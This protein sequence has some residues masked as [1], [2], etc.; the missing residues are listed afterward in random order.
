MNRP[1]RY[2][3][4]EWGLKPRILVWIIPIFL[5]ASVLAVIFNYLM[6]KGNDEKRVEDYV[7][8]RRMD[9]IYL[10]SL[11]SL[12]MYLMNL[13]LG[14]EEEA[15]F[16]KED[17]QL[18]YLNYLKNQEPSFPHI[19]SL[20][21]LNG[22]ELL[23]IENGDIKP[24]HQGFSTSSYLAKIIASKHGENPSLPALRDQQLENS[25][26]V[27][28]FPIFSEINNKVVGGIVYEYQIPVQQLMKHSRGVFVFNILLSSISTFTA[29]AMINFALG[30]IIRPLNQL[31]EAAQKMLT[32]D[33]SKKIKVQG[34]GE[35]RAL[36]AA[37]ED[38]RQRLE[39]RIRELRDNSRKLEAIIDFLP[40]PTFIIDQDRKV[41]FWNIAMEEMTGLPREEVIGKG[42][43]KY[44]EPFYGEKRPVLID[45][46]FET[47]EEV[48]EKYQ[49][50]KQSNTGKIEASAWCPTLRGQNRMLH[51]TAAGL[52]DDA[53]NMFG[54]IESISD[55]TEHYEMEQEKK[56]LQSQLMHA[57]KLKA[58]GTL[59]GG[60]AHD[61]NNLIHAIQGYTEILLLERRPDADYKKLKAIEKAVKRA[62]ELT[63]QL[64]IFS[65]KAKSKLR[66]MDLNQELRETNNL[67]QRIIPKMTNIEL[68]LEEDLK[69]VY[70][71]S[72]Q[73]EQV[74]MNLA[75]NARDA[76][77]EGGRLIIE[78]ANTSLGESFC[79]QNPGSK[80]G[81]Y[82][83][84]RV[85]D[86]G[87][88]MDEETLVHIYEPFFTTKEVGKGTGLGLA[89]VYG[90]VKNHSGYI[91]CSS[92]LGK[93]T[94]FTIYLPV[95]T[96]VEETAEP[97][98]SGS[99][100]GGS[101][102]ILLVDDDE[103]IRTLGEDLLTT[104]GYTVLLAVDGEKGLELYQQKRQQIDLIVLD[105]IMP[106]MGGKKCLE[107]LRKINPN[108]KVIVASGYSHDEFGKETMD[109]DNINFLTKPY[110]TKKVLDLVREALSKN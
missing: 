9:L 45:L 65:R 20:V 106:G 15:A 4:I 2:R 79:K 97:E 109:S 42:D 72:L 5:V 46:V 110:Q 31:T 49:N 63:S 75:I 28:V 38:L 56:Q 27:D 62:G 36:A 108:V 77:P 95:S 54:A 14:L 35:T 74:I 24:T 60:I 58:I 71:D 100:E 33:L 51:G 103:S 68:H 41:I 44:A 13:K 17:V 82:V 93:G 10:A 37:F 18:F 88:G 19:F 76:M 83:I 102:T 73:L 85:A 29:L 21:S 92:E 67:L 99:L 12:H 1:E 7:L 107:E 52:Y 22:E 50:V 40:L 87:K 69:I 61:F 98:V 47:H 104:F 16:V 23:R 70:A 91:T 90:I 80:P 26:I 94:V 34:H 25:P 96:Q 89:M 78:T 48:K 59:A 6:A 55:M 64:L 32:G 84:L 8:K 105:M 86:T 101:E 81:K 11:P 39:N 3:T 57:Q 30:L 53:G 43:L 66:P